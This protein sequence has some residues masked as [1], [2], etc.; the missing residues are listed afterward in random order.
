[1]YAIVHSSYTGEKWPTV[2]ATLASKYENKWSPS[3]VKV[4]S[5]SN[6]VEE[7]L[8]ELGQFRPAYTCFVAHFDEAT[9]IFVT[10]VHR[11]TRRYDVTTPF[12][13]TIWGILTGPSEEDVLFALRQ[14]SLQVR[15]VLGGTPVNLTKFE[16]GSWYSEGEPCVSYHKRNIDQEACK[17]TC[18]RD[19][20]PTIVRELSSERNEEKCTGADM[21]ITSGHATEYNWSIG[22]SYRNG[23]LVCKDGHMYGQDMIG[24]LHP[25][26]H[27][28]R[29]KIL[30]AAGNCLMGNICETNCMALAWMRSVGVVQM[31]G[32]L[33]PTWFGYGGWGVHNYFIGLPGVM[34]FCESFF[35]NTQSLLYLLHTKYPTHANIEIDDYEG[36]E[37][38]C[39][40]LIYD[41]DMVAFYG[42]PA[43]DSRLVYQ[44]G[45]QDYVITVTQEEGEIP[46]STEEGKE[47]WKRY[48]LKLTVYS[49][50]DR[51]PIYIFPR[52]VTDYRLVKGSAVVTCRFVL[53]TAQYGP[54]TPGE[55]HTVIYETLIQ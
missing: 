52:S 28:G 55:E 15:R 2:L 25:I 17:E 45:K 40:G 27:N 5:Y 20:T 14:E 9:P 11:L 1:M 43:F 16:T 24:I 48:Q 38:E 42:D 44:E 19:T 29:A 3:D 6:Q 35:A 18:P 23:S 54:Y 49:K 4:I 30:S 50:F 7:S 8:K 13:D 53:F 47:R 31:T 21:I 10:S 41:R 39:A 33:V 36:Q 34:T 32:Y 22:Y 12:T 46:Q 37:R 26:T 51:F